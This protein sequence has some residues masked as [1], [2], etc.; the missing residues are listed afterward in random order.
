MLD[1][2]SVASTIRGI[3]WCTTTWLGRSP[4]P[5]TLRWLEAASVFVTSPVLD[6][7]ADV[8]GHRFAMLAS[9]IVRLDRLPCVGDGVAMQAHHAPQAPG[10]PRCH[11]VN[12]SLG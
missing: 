8:D 10:K 2:T 9:G 4:S 7:F 5:R 3:T 1:G 6:Q 11:R 12:P